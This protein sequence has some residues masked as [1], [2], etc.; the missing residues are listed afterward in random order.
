MTAAVEAQIG[1]GELRFLT[2]GS[3]ANDIFCSA[4]DFDEQ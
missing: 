3:R 2:C 4:Q 1:I